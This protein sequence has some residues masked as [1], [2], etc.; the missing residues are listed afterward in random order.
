M[1]LPGGFELVIVLLI[2]LGLA[3]LAG[4]VI[5]SAVRADKRR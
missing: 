4:F 3:A 2:M 1:T 5:F